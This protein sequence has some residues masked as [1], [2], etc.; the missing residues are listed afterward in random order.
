MLYNAYEVLKQA[1][2]TGGEIMP[3]EMLYN[4]YEVLKQYPTKCKEH[5]R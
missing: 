1:T 3:V 4:A 2:P 5:N